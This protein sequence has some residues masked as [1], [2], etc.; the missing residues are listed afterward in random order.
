MRRV[1]KPSK[2]YSRWVSKVEQ[3]QKDVPDQVIF[4]VTFSTRP[5][6]RRWPAERSGATWTWTPGR[7]AT[8]PMRATTAVA[9]SVRPPPHRRP[10]A[11]R[12]SRFRSIWR[13]NRVLWRHFRRSENRTTK[14]Q[15]GIIKVIW[16][17]MS[18]QCSK[19]LGIVVCRHM[20][21]LWR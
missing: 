7:T 10:S 2:N 12:R 5:A 4:I 6:L 3:G 16:V 1:P 21:V 15:V 9:V 14:I 20:V 13:R 17:L 19:G 18:Y 8:A 11:E